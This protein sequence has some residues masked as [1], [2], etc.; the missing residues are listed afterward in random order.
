MST[1]ATRSCSEAAAGVVVAV[2]AL[3]A[4]ASV[5]TGVAVPRE[6]RRAAARAVALGMEG[7]RMD[8]ALANAWP[9][10]SGYC[11]ASGFGAGSAVQSSCL[12]WREGCNARFRHAFRTARSERG[13]ALWTGWRNA[14]HGLG[15][16]GACG[17][18]RNVFRYIGGEAAKLRATPLKP[19]G[20]LLKGLL[21]GDQA[22]CATRPDPRETVRR[23]IGSRCLSRERWL[24]MRSSAGQVWLNRQE[25]PCMQ[26]LFSV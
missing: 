2:P 20:S 3:G 11:G 19:A 25:V 7:M 26:V 18:R 4:L 10:A 16:I 8:H 17:H 24:R 9:A 21:G 6:R 12:V 1:L 5:A 22:D 14:R 15:R 23:A 13:R